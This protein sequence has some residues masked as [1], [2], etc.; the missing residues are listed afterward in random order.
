MSQAMKKYY[1]E[2]PTFKLSGGSRVPG[3]RVRSPEVLVPLLHH[4]LLF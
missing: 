3:P 1:F 4:A 2:G